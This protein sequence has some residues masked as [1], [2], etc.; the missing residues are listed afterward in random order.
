MARES[1]LFSLEDG[2]LHCHLFGWKVEISKAEEKLRRQ[3]FSEEIIDQV[4]SAIL[5]KN[6]EEKKTKIEEME[7]VI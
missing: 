1:R 3:G 5:P 7:L 2:E 6:R 4:M